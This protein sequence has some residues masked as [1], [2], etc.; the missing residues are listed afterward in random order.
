MLCWPSGNRDEREFA[1]PDR[2]DVTRRPNRHLAYGRG[3]HTCLGLHVAQLGMRVLFEELLARLES[4]ELA[5]A[6]VYKPANFVGGLDSLP[7]TL[8]FRR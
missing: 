3:K 4:L 5:G 2:F 7:V 8:T 6:P 1:D